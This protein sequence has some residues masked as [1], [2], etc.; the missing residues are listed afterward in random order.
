MVV[1]IYCMIYRI[2]TRPEVYV[3]D[4]TNR[5]S[6]NLYYSGQPGCSYVFAVINVDIL[7]FVMQPN[8]S[9]LS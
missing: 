2:D 3:D 9:Q 8:R 7:W 1:M 4:M 6:L 5:R